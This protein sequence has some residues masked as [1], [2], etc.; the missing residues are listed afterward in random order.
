M[1]DAKAPSA[2]EVL[3]GQTTVYLATLDGDQPRVR[4]V[5][6]VQHEGHLFVLTGSRNNK[7]AQIRQHSKVE[8]VAP[9]RQ[10]EH[11]GYVRFSATATLEE[12]PRVRAEVAKAVSFFTEFWKSPDDPRY[13]LVRIQPVTIEYLKPGEL[14]PVQIPKLDFRR[15]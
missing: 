12:Q 14:Q 2:E 15:R 9:V 5:T 1:G 3:R 10:G 8:V 6:L 13:A 11:T 7:I 4:P